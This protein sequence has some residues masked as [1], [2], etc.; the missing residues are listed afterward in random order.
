MFLENKSCNTCVSPLNKEFFFE[1]ILEP[2]G[3]QYHLKNYA[4]YLKVSTPPIGYSSNQDGE[5][6]VTSNI[7]CY[8]F[9]PLE[10]CFPSHF[11]CCD[12]VQRKCYNLS[13]LF[14]IVSSTSFLGHS[15][16]SVHCLKSFKIIL[17]WHSCWMMRGT[18]MLSF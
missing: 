13:H 1:L 18:L 12:F 11:Q 16:V 14:L 8:K 15:C 17:V 10:S 6:I 2:I 4:Y 3:K 5:S 7:I 9:G